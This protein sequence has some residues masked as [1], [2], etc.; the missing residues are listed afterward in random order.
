MSNVGIK[1][2]LF[3]KCTESGCWLRYHR[4]HTI[5][6]KPCT[7]QHNFRRHFGP[8]TIQR[9]IWETLGA[10]DKMKGWVCPGN[11]LNPETG[12]LKLYWSLCAPRPGPPLPSARCQISPADRLKTPIIVS[13]YNFIYT[14]PIMEEGFQSCL[15]GEGLLQL[16]WNPSPGSCVIGEFCTYKSTFMKI[17][18]APSVRY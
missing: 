17:T 14:T 10:G 4:D 3:G 6:S 5:E 18:L 8:E 2:I 15:E 13:F 11:V 16:F 12:K 9:N 7:I 1:L